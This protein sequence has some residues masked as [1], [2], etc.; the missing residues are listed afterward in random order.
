ML[1]VFPAQQSSSELQ[2]DVLAG[3]QQVLTVVC[4]Q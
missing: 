1:Q 4:H 3:K 2:G